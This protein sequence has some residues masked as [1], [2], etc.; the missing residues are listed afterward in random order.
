M[1]SYSPKE[2]KRWQTEQFDA[3]RN[4]L[5][6]DFQKYSLSDD[7][8]G[9]QDSIDDDDD[10]DH[11]LGPR[12]N[13]YIDTR[14]RYYPQN[15]E[16]IEELRRLRALRVGE[17]LLRQEERNRLRRWDSINR[18]RMTLNKKPIFPVSWDPKAMGYSGDKS[19]VVARWLE[20]S[21]LCDQILKAMAKESKLA[22][23]VEGHVTKLLKL[24]KRGVG[25]EF[26]TA[27]ERALLDDAVWKRS[28]MYGSEE[29]KRLLSIQ[30]R[31]QVDPLLRP[32]EV[33]GRETAINF[34]RNLKN[35][36]EGKITKQEGFLKDVKRRLR[37]AGGWEHE[38]PPR[39]VLHDAFMI[40][41]GELVD[42]RTGAAVTLAGVA[43]AHPP[44]AAPAR[45]R[46]FRQW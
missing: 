3:L 6:G 35:R 38:W 16:D 20:A 14:S 7:Y 41:S 30:S 32:R 28:I 46:F 34:L 13:T 29:F 39:D 9:L 43:A 8:F 18:V 33:E 36:V 19:Q 10:Y 26:G 2:R 15:R 37:A 4:K 40:R 1:S 5:W 21:R 12:S 22:L 42:P 25:T 45:P 17:D 31:L 27:A 23:E 44:G 24:V 11:Y